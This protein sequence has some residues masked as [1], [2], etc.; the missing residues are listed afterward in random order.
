MK[1][2]V[3]TLLKMRAVLMATEPEPERDSSEIMSI[4]EF[5]LAAESYAIDSSFVSEVSS[6]KDFTPLPGVPS[7]ILGIINLRGKILTVLD[8]KKFFN[9][10]EKGIGELNK[11]I[12]LQNDIMEFGILA[13]EIIGTKEIYIEE[14]L[15]IPSAI[16]GIG[17]KYL[18]GVT[19]ERL[20]I[21]SAESILSD[22]S[23]VVNEEI[24]K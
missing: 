22:K 14:I 9:M 4:I 13:D 3:S 8:M 19:K 6:L 2:E 12:I 5:Q 23:I 1:K 18:K 24:K 20:I 15:D 17:G 7:Y 11:V 21:L 16:A 10:P